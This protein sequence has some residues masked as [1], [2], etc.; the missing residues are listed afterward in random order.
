MGIALAYIYTDWFDFLKGKAVDYSAPFYWVTDLA[1]EAED[2][3]DNRM[4]SR[5]R[6]IQE[7]EQLR[8]ELLVHKRKLQQMASLA[9]E[10]VRL[11]ELLNSAESLNDRVLITELIGVSP[12]PMVHKVIVN[13]GSDHGV[14]KGQALLDASGLMGQVVEVGNQSAQVLLITDVTHALP[15]QIN[16]NG[17]RLIAE[18]IGDLYQLEINHISNTT[19]IRVGDLLVSSG[20]GQRFPVGY[21]VA[22]ITEIIVDPGR[23]FVR[24]LARPKAELN[25]S[26]HVLLVFDPTLAEQG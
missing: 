17:V 9:A 10:N 21:P 14:Y 18:G 22:E 7:N 23:P 2:W 4:M 15:V 20:L 13:R 19:D 11:R 12:D 3:A 25:R 16:R 6:L 1:D 24:A 26:R 5:A 8:T